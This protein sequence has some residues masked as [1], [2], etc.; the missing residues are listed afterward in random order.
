MRVF[1][2]YMALFTLFSCGKDQ[3]DKPILLNK[4]T[5]RFAAGDVLTFKAIP[6]QW[7]ARLLSLTQP[8]PV[9]LMPTNDGFRLKMQNK[10][11]ITEGPAQLVIYNDNQ[12]FYYDIY[13]YNKTTGQITE[14]D[15]RFP[16]TVNP[17]SSLN[18]QKMI[19]QIDQWRNVLY[20]PNSNIYFNEEIIS[21]SPK[22][23][24]IR[25]QKDKPISAYYIQP[26]SATSVAVKFVYNKIA[27]EYI[28]TA[29]PITDKYKNIV[30]NGT[31]VN[32]NYEDKEKYHLMQVQ[33]HN[34]FAEARIP[35]GRKTYNLYANI[36]N[37]LSK[38]ITL[39]H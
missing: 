18:Q 7:Q 26:G 20:L 33:L 31:V 16:K 35:A 24:T 22:T 32:F 4:S 11:G 12:Y 17:D 14:R 29:G 28:V 30:A 34:G 27:D 1:V 36:N 19:H 39:K 9:V 10:Y 3:V 23:N 37:N 2:L 38:T 21:L 13:L 5:V 8:I 25:A 15:Y 6:A